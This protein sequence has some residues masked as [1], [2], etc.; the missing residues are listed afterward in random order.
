MALFTINQYINFGKAT[1]FL[2]A[3]YVAEGTFWGG[4]LLQQQSA[5]MV[6]IVTDALAWEYERRL[7]VIAQTPADTIGI[8]D[9]DILLI[10][11]TDKLLA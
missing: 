1:E 4:T 7:A 2:M 5:V 10:N 8:N 9:T 6:N 11:S 3:N